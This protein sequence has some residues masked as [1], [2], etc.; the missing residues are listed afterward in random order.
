MQEKTA[1]VF[2]VATAN[3]VSQLPP[4][5]LRKGRFDEIFFSDLP[6]DEERLEILKIHLTRFKR[7]PAD[8]FLE[9][10]VSQTDGFSGAELEQVIVDALFA[11]FFKNQE[12]EI[13]DL[14][15]AANKTIPLSKTMAEHIKD[16]RVWAESRAR[17]AGKVLTA[18]DAEEVIGRRLEL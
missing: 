14:L 9:S 17:P 5:M 4:E 16:L 1:S 12:P 7:N 10:V 18:Q 15:V 2:V 11:G 3:N 13:T 8:F 6:N